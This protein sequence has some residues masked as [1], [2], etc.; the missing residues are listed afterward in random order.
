M[1]YLDHNATTP[2][3]AEVID[4]MSVLQ[5]TLFGNASSYY[6]IAREAKAVLEKSR[7]EIAWR[8]GAEPEEIVFTSGG[9]E[10]DN[11]AIRGAARALKGN[12]R[13]IITSSIEHHAVLKTCQDLEMIGYRV[14]YLPVDSQCRVYPRDV[15][16]AISPETILISIMHA[17]NETGVIQ[18]IEEIG[19]LAR[20]RG[21][22]FHTDAVQSLGKIH[23]SVT[24]M[25]ADMVSLSAHKVYGPKGIGALYIR[26]GTPLHPLVTG[27]SQEYGLRAG[28]EN[29]PSIVGF[30]TAASLAL[31]TMEADSTRIAALRNRLETEIANHID[32][33]KINGKGAHRLPNTSN[34]CFPGVDGESILLHLDL[35]EICASSGSACSTASASPSHVLLAMGLAP[36][37]AQSTVRFSLGRETTDQ[38]IDV[39]VESL[40]EITSRLRS[41]SSL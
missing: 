9:T 3:R 26:N 13:H 12:G 32:G 31:Q 7:A 35:S 29:V 22:V 8:I 36:Q 15:E 19:S 17:N 38:D 16:Q 21:I 6:R 10:S 18:P 39:T 14:S 30:S 24:E 23:I 4:V 34:M 11:T 41:I 5:K 40:I 20:D 25:K 27:G 33:V 37:E 28:T 2:I 1:I